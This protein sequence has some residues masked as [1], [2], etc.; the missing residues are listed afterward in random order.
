MSKS[1]LVQDG[2]VIGEEI[3]F[4]KIFKHYI[5][6]KKNENKYVF[7]II[8]ADNEGTLNSKICIIK[9]WENAKKYLASNIENCYEDDN[10][11]YYFEG[12]VFIVEYERE[13][14]AR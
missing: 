10:S 6:K 8:E 12:E 1:K 2:K 13:D 5:K 14:A 9:K 7:G 4:F 3:T 11:G